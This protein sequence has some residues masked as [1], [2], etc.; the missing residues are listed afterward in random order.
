MTPLITLAL[1][2]FVPVLILMFLRIN[3]VLVFLSICLGDVLVQ[4]VAPDSKTMITT[5]AGSNAHL[6]NMLSN[7]IDIVLLLLPVVLT[8][9]F[10]IH[11][12]HGGAKLILNLLPAIGVGL[13][14]T[15]LVIPLL[16]AGLRHNIVDSSLWAEVERAENLI[17]GSS[18]IICLLVLWMQRPKKSGS[19][20]GKHGKH[21]RGHDKE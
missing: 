10:M 12:V 7:N 9:I 19:G 17:V 11:T 8:A 5:F 2:I 6:A 1:I 3:A 13:L 15:L 4:F 16:S 20:E 14:A 21:G 18:S